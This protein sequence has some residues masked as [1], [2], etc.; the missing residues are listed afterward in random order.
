MPR[1]KDEIKDP[2]YQNGK[3][4]KI[5]LGTKVYIG[6]TIKS[7][8]RRFSNHKS[9]CKSFSNGKT[10]KVCA[11]FQLF[12]S[13]GEPQMHLLEAFPCSSKNEL[14]TREEYWRKR[15]LEDLDI[16][17][18]NSKRAFRTEEERIEQWAANYQ[19]NRQTILAYRCEKIICP[20]C[21][22][23]IARTNISEH[24]RSLKCQAELRATLF[25]EL[26]FQ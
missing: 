22:A 20:I 8:S 5:Q 12:E 21:K 14:D 3:I 18:V 10:T 2:K 15:L 9:A 7:L 16:E 17:V 23:Q 25:S 26:P 6:S 19:A 24:Q 13:Q 4:Y 1:C 11:S